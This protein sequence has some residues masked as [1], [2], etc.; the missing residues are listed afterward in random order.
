MTLN[1]RPSDVDH[2]QFEDWHGSTVRLGDKIVYATISGRSA[3]LNI[4]IVRRIYEREHDYST[5]PKRHLTVELVDQKWGWRRTEEQEAK[6]PLSTLNFWDRC[7]RY[8]DPK[9]S[10]DEPN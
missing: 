6:R 1:K 8:I 10:H 2:E 3:K 4:G 7:L 5:K 9:D